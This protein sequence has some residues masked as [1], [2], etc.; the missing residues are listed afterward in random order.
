MNIFEIMAHLYTDKNPKWIDELEESEIQPVIIQLW[1]VMN[2]QVRVQTRWLDKYTFNLPPKM[3]LS[4]AWSVLPKYQKTPFVKYI[5]KVEDDEEYLFILNK[6]RQQFKLSDN[7][8]KANKIRL[9]NE[10]KKDMPSWFTYYGVEKAN[11]KK[12]YLDFNVMKQDDKPQIKKPTGL[13]K[14]GM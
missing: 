11:W 5:K 9:I 7:D 4:L 3:W 13:S 1:L 8:F 10:I 6:I 12:Y 14:W 2:D